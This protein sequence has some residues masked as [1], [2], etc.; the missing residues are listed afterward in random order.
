MRRYLRW[1]KR[2]KSNPNYIAQLFHRFDTWCVP[3]NTQ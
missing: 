1:A 3:K 2:L